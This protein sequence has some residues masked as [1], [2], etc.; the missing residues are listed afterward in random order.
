MAE[1]SETAKDPKAKKRPVRKL[2]PLAPKASVETLECDAFI[3]GLFAEFRSNFSRLTSLTQHSLELEARI[4]M[5]EK[6]LCLTRDHLKMTIDK[7][8][9][10]CVP[11]DWES[12]FAEVRFVGIK[13]GDACTALLQ[14]H[15]K[16]TPEELLT[17]LNAGMFRFRTSSPLR[18]IHAALLRQRRA[19]KLGDTW[20]WSG[21][22][23]GAEQVEMRLRVAP[24]VEPVPHR[25]HASNENLEA[26]GTDQ[27]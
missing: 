16:L 25:D 10:A 24:K 20:V 7:A 22:G 15:G 8:G 6:A 14:E 23:A 18:E 11:T 17:G 19:T 13:L 3:G 21:D 26:T 27:S 2:P 1:K 9:P 4:Q 5:T 12:L